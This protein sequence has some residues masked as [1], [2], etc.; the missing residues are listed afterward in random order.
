MDF[1]SLKESHAADMNLVNATKVEPGAF[2]ALAKTYSFFDGSS[3]KIPWRNLNIL[4]IE[5]TDDLVDEI[6]E[7]CFNGT[8]T[9]LDKKINLEVLSKLIKV[10]S[11]S[12]VKKILVKS[13][14]IGRAH[15]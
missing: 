1:N 14:Q 8:I 9:V 13:C 5:V 4:N 2:R 15:V 3:V 7:M 11:G 12:R 6:A 10:T